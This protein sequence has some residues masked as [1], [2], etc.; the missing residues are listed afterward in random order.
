ML[1]GVILHEASILKVHIPKFMC[2]LCVVLVHHA[3]YYC[4]TLIMHVH[5]SVESVC[6]SG[7]HARHV[8]W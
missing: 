7:Y 1:L 3:Y 4:F 8:G 2:L 6:T 5:V